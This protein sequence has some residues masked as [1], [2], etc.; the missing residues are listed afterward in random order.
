MTLNTNGEAAPTGDEF[1][2]LRALVTGGASGIGLAVVQRLVQAGCRVAVLDLEVAQSDGNVLSVQC[3]VSDSAS[4]SSA[5]TRVAQEFG[6]I[7][8]VINNAGIGA[9]GTVEDNSDDEWRRVFEV[10]VYGMVRVA[11]SALPFLRQSRHAAIV[12]TFGS[13]P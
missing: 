7:D 8:I 11:R 3:D 6:G 2:G 10:N 5:V 1:Q 12:N 9:Q 4:V 13:V